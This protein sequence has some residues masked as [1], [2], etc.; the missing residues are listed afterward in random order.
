MCLWP[1]GDFQ[2]VIKHRKETLPSNGSAS[3]SCVQ[4][5]A[6][7]SDLGL[8]LF[9]KGS[10]GQPG[11]QLIFPPIPATPMLCLFVSFQLS[12]LETPKCCQSLN[13]PYKFV[14]HVFLSKINLALTGPLSSP[15]M[16]HHRADPPVICTG[17]F[18][19]SGWAELSGRRGLWFSVQ[20][21]RAAR[22]NGQA[23][24][25]AHL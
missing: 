2:P 13:K 16:K 3:T 14:F 1:C 17:C 8:L 24:S 7:P 22:E 18:P 12:D 23:A 19:G 21:G 11:T 4:P 15:P 25:S 5:S 10:Q 20:P 9:A 6:Q